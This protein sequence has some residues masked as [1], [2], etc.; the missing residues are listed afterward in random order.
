MVVQYGGLPAP[1]YEG[2]MNGDG[3]VWYGRRGRKEGRGFAE[4]ERER[5]GKSSEHICPVEIGS[6]A[7]SL[8]AAAAAKD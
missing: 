1:E 8:L 4:R 3:M 7:A 2:W 5:I 6:D